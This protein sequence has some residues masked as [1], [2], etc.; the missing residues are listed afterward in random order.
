MKYR[1]GMFSM[2]RLLYGRKLLSG[3]THALSSLEFYWARLLFVC[4]NRTST[5]NWLC[6][7]MGI[8]EKNTI[9]THVRRHLIASLKFMNYIPYLVVNTIGMTCVFV[10]GIVKHA[11]LITM[12]KTW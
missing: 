2:G 10:E 9:K 11:H 4:D 12:T 8:K 1:W 5:F 3:M 6:G 7:S